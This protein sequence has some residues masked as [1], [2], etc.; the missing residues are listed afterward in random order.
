MTQLAA[1]RISLAYDTATIV[2][3]L[4]LTIEEGTITT[5]IGPNG[6]GKSTLLRALS[7]LMT[8]T[9]GA[10]M[11]DG[12]AI[13]DL[14][15][16]EVAKR[17]GLLSQQ[18]VV[19]DGVTVEELA[20]RG[21]YPHQAFLQPPTE[22]DRQ[23]V[24]HALD[25]AGMTGLRLRPVSELSGGQRQRAWIAMVLAQETPML[26]LDEPTTYLDIA[27][28]LEVME[29]VERLNRDEGRTIVM[30]LHDINEAARVSDRLVAMRDGRIVGDGTP[31]EVLQ[32]ELLTQLFGVACDVLPHPAP[33]RCAG[34]CVPRSQ[35]MWGRAGERQGSTGFAISNAR[36]GYG[37]TVV[38]DDLTLTIPGGRITALVGPN[39]CGKSTLMRSCARLQK[40]GAGTIH[41]DG[42]SIASGS[43][44]ALA[45]RL[46]LLNQEASAPED[47]LVEDLVTAGRTPH[48]GLLRRWTR[49]DEEMVDWAIRQCRLEELRYRTV[50]S[51]SGGQ[52]QRAWIAMSLVQDT[53]VLLLDEPTTFLDIAAQ[54]DLLDII[55]KLNREQGK[56]VVMVIHDINLAARYADHIVAMREGRIVAQG[57]PETVMTCPL[58]HRIFDV[59]ADVL[60]HPE[61]GTP[62]MVP[63]RSVATVPPVA[64]QAAATGVA[65]PA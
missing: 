48:Q 3:D 47:V 54:V 26:L 45:R 35:A 28:Q 17:L 12:Q 64:V 21:R 2:S 15:S 4:D 63:L 29:L 61:L 14:P 50:G 32:P 59:D 5:I 56:T 37:P 52:R 55:W 19:P 44:K 9:S 58:L 62:M 23:A 18:A 42:K 24:E 38:S 40:L 13:H 25:L 10:V 31:T 34:Y 65:A 6:C 57:T 36:T 20:H 60:L 16:R 43:H 22:R 49:E 53:P 11:L 51:L 1:E 30:V 27:H 39:A 7:R 33:T 41:L 8:P 46:A